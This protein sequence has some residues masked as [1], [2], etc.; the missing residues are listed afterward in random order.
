[1]NPKENDRDDGLSSLLRVWQV[2]PLGSA[3]DHRVLSSYRAHLLDDP[4]WKRVLRARVAIPVPALALL[5]LL[6]LAFWLSRPPAN[7]S[8]S[9]GSHA[10]LIGTSGDM[11]SVVIATPRNTSYITT[12]EAEGFQPVRDA[13]IVVTRRG[14][15]P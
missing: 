12:V 10:R 2:P 4:L 1:M 11:R 6:A 14:A 13:K 15:R 3:L 9:T 8:P 7:S 5:C